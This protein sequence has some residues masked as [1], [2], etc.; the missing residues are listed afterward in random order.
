MPAH[1]GISG[2]EQADTL[3]TTAHHP[4]VPLTRTVASDFSR[5]R[6]RQLLT[7]LHPDASVANGKGPKP[8]PGAGLTKRERATLLRLR[9]GCVWTAARL[10]SKGRS[11]SPACERCGDPETL[12]HLLWL[13]RAGAG[14]LQAY[15]HLPTTGTPCDDRRRTAVPIASQTPGSP[16]PLGVCGGDRDH[17]LPLSAQYL[18]ASLHHPPPP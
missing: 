7:T 16:K 6:L 14:M 11:P 13:P 12:E 10:F 9:T 17:H 2:N 1:V 18:P 15:H 5:Q 8:L 3:A 4:G